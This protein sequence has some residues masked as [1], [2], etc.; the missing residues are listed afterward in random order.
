[1]S[2]S[3]YQSIGI[4]CNDISFGHSLTIPFAGFAQ[5]YLS[6][7]PKSRESCCYNSNRIRHDAT[8]DYRL[9][10]HV[11]FYN[12]RDEAGSNPNG[13]SREAMIELCHVEV[14]GK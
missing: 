9:G 14:N 4:L 1:L 12:E 13:Y 11:I 8:I 6:M 10:K 2:I 7:I 5:T 3:I